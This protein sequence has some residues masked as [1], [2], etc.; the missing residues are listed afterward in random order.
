MILPRIIATIRQAGFAELMAKGLW[1]FDDLRLS[2]MTLS[3]QEY[4][5]KMK[6]DPAIN[7]F[8]TK[9]AKEDTWKIRFHCL[10]Y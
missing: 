5:L 8:M 3:F 6:E 9:T 2:V 1:F 7:T 10:F 4:I